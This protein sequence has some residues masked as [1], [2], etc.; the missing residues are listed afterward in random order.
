MC[1]YPE[2]P[3]IPRN[4]KNIEIDDK[5]SEYLHNIMLIFLP[6]CFASIFNYYI[7]KQYKYLKKSLF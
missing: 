6:T 1:T 7:L 4:T 2:Y 5:E 3:R